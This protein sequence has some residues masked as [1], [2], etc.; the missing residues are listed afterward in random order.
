MH[1]FFYRFDGLSLV[2]GNKT[3]GFCVQVST[4]AMKVL[5]KVAIDPEEHERL[6]VQ[7]RE[8]LD[9]AQLMPK[10]LRHSAGVSMLENTACPRF[11]TTDSMFGGSL[12][13]NPEELGWLLSKDNVEDWVGPSFSFTPHNVDSAKQAMTLVL[14]VET[15]GEWAYD[16]LQL[17][18]YGRQ[19]DVRA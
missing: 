1:E 9:R 5:A 14:L 10:T 17:A 16:K 2:S 13:A 7:M 12:G 11:F 15:W 18:G 3:A 4:A 19:R 6:V 8:R